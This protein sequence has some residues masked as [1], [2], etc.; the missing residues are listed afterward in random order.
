MR[1]WGRH[2]RPPGHRV[3][4]GLAH[5][6]LTVRGCRLPLRQHSSLYLCI[7]SNIFFSI[8]SNISSIFSIIYNISSIFFN[9]VGADLARSSPRSSAQAFLVQ[10]NTSS[11]PPTTSH[12]R[13]SLV[14]TCLAHVL[15][16]LIVW[17][18][19]AQQIVPSPPV[20]GIMAANSPVTGSRLF[21]Q[22]NSFRSSVPRSGQVSQPHT[23]TAVITGASYL[24]SWFSINLASG[25]E[26]RKYYHPLYQYQY[27]LNE[28]IESDPRYGNISTLRSFLLF[29]HDAV[30]APRTFVVS[31]LVFSP[32]LPAVPGKVT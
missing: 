1:R 32:L 6:G 18:L 15:T 19:S 8:F 4:P 31:T 23:T 27:R 20:V 9:T 11:P 10:Y 3:T 2:V 5:V 21:S 16:A 14:F 30:D 13:L 28:W 12:P 29:Q 17:L 7:F 24:V 22:S 25:S 26:L